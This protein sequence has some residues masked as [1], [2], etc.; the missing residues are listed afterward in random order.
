LRPDSSRRFDAFY[1]LNFFT[2]R[3]T[4]FF[5]TVDDPTQWP[6]LLD[7]IQVEI[8]PA[9]AVAIAKQVYR[10]IAIQPPVVC[11]VKRFVAI[12]DKSN[13]VCRVAR[14]PCWLQKLACCFKCSLARRVCYSRSSTF[15]TPFSQ[16][17]FVF[18]K[19]QPQQ[20]QTKNFD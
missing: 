18:Q 13:V 3:P 11:S 14:K 8:D 6:L 17:F 16:R 19:G 1:V 2:T 9:V 10:S 15:W 7:M 20:K 4:N 12:F 5:T